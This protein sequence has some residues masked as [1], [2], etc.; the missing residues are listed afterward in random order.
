MK[1]R[2]ST[3]R[4]LKSIA[5]IFRIESAKPPYNKQRT[6][7]KALERIKDYFKRQDIYVAIVNNKIVGFVNSDMDPDTKNQAWINEFWI[8]KDYQGK[9]IGKRFMTEIEDIYKKKGAK[10]FKLVANTRKGGARG[11]YKKLNYKLDNN[12][13]FMEKRLK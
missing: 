3:K 13:I 6:P 7:K 11:F 10:I 1:I 2:K 9:G 5:K 12:M 4:D 8:L